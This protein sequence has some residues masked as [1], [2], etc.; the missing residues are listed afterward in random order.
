[1]MLSLIASDSFPRFYS[2]MGNPLYENT[3]GFQVLMQSKYF[4]HEYA[5]IDKHIVSSNTIQ[6]Y[7]HR[8]DI[9]S[10]S[11]QRIDYMSELRLLKKSNDALLKRILARLEL[12]FKKKKYQFLASLHT[13]KA[14]DIR[15]SRAVKASFALSPE[16]EELSDEELKFVNLQTSFNTYKKELLKARMDNSATSCLND[17]TALYHYFLEIQSLLDQK[18]CHQF[19]TSYK[20]MLVYLHSLSRT[21]PYD[22]EDVIK[23]KEIAKQYNT[24]L[25]Q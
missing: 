10:T 19:I 20:Q 9:E 8:I 22:N 14:R 21:C 1:M 5:Q 6:A 18:K 23:A 3:E 12:L 17:V 25:C 24:E 13:N 4:K 7:G 16:N 11:T 2:S 15:E